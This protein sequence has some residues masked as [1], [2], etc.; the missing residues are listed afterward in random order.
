MMTEIVAGI[1][2]AVFITAVTRVKRA[3]TWP[4]VLTADA[5]LVLICAVSGLREA[6]FIIG[7]YMSVFLVDIFFGKKSEKN[8]T[9]KLI[10]VIVNGFAGCVCILLYKIT[11]DIAFLLAYYTS[12]FEVLADSIASDVGVLSKKQP[13]DICTWKKVPSGMSGGISTLGMSVSGAACICAG[14]AASFA[15][16]LSPVQTFIVIAVPYIGMLLDSVIG[17]RIQVKYICM[18][19][20]IQTEQQMHCGS[21]TRKVS[22][23]H[24]VNNHI[25]NFICNMAAFIGFLMARAL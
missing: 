10:Q 24:A 17:S 16:S 9:R 8:Q 20:G 7:M 4:A 23:V 3:L 5:M 18:C 1:V 15:L 6:M 13:R 11:K 22:G 21:K 19:C 2:L 12:I 25:V 14:L